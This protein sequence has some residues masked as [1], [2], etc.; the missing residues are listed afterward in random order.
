MGP[1]SVLLVGIVASEG[2]SID[3]IYSSIM[4]G[5]LVLAILSMTG[6]FGYLRTLFTPRVIATT[7]ILIAFTL[8][9]MITNLIT[10][11]THGVSGFLNLVFALIFVLSMFIANKLTTGIWKATLTIW[12]I[13]LGSLIYYFLF[14]TK[15]TNNLDYNLISPFFSNFTLKI[16]LEPGLLVSF[17]IC[18]LALSVNDLGSIQ[19][20]NELINPDHKEKRITRGIIFT[21]LG[22]ILAGFFGVIGSV[23]F[24]ISPGIIVSTRCASKYTLVP[25]GVGL[26][27]LSFFPGI[28]AFMGSV[29]SVVIGSALIYL[30]CS[31]ISAGLIVAF[32]S[33]EKFT[34][35]HGLVM[36]LS[37]MLSII[38]SFLPTEVL[39]TFPAIL[40]P[41][42][43]NGFVVGVMAV[44]TMERL[45]IKKP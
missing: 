31:Q 27:I 9:P 22:N 41:I 23:N 39:N 43:G 1:A 26:L 32:N 42:L 36:G 40:R 7:L 3:A 20:V 28:I 16:T 5:G 33:E 18:F 12:G 35:E 6:L 17:L 21:G 19:A 13:L 37:L 2:S 38:I 30:M 25:M 8:T 15:I 29:P 34:F 14:P 45:I 10:N 11:T 44:L 24:S 4:V